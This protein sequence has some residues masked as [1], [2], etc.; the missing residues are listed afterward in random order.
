MKEQIEK[1]INGLVKTL[2]KIGTVIVVML[3]LANV[4]YAAVPISDG[5]DYPV[6]NRDNLEGW[7][8]SLSLGESWSLYYGHLGEDYLKNSASAK[9]EN[10]YSASNGVVY[11][12]YTGDPSGW[13]GVV[14]IKHAPSSGNSFSVSGLTLPDS[15]ETSINTVYTLYGHLNL[16]AIYVY[17]NENVGRGT[18]IGKIGLVEKFPTPHLHFEVKNQAAIDNEAHN[19]GTGHGYS[20][21]DNSAPNHYKPSNF[22][23]ANRPQTSPLIGDWNNDNIDET[24]TYN[25]R[26]LTFALDNGVTLVKSDTT[27]IPEAGDIALVGDWNKDGI[28]TVGV[29]RPKDAKFFLDNDNDGVIDPENDQ[30]FLFGNIGDY[31]I[32]GDWDKDGKDEVGVYRISDTDEN[33][34]TFFLKKSD[35]TSE[36]SFD[37]T[38]TDTPI[39][40]D[41]NNDGIDDVGVFRRNDPDHGENAV[42][43]LKFGDTVV[44]PILYGNNDDIP[45]AGK[46][47]VDKLTRVGIYRPNTGEFIF[48]P[49]P[50]F[51]SSGKL[52]LIF[53]V[54]TTG[55][56]WD[57]IDAVKA[58]ANEIVEALDF[59]GL[60]YRVTIANYKDYPCCGYGG[61]KDYVYKLDLP[62]TTKENK[63]DIIDAINNLGA[64]GGA[65]TPESVY[66]ALVHSMEDPNK[67][68]ANSANSGWRNGVTKAIII[69]GD[70]PPH[71]PELWSGGHTLADVI[72]TSESIDP[73]L[74]YSVIIG[75][76]QSAYDAFAEI[77]E[78]TNGNVYTSPT[79]NDVVAAILEAIGDISEPPENRGV[80]VN[81]APSNNE[82]TTGSSV[83]YAVNVTNIGSLNDAY[84]ISL[85]LNNF[86][87]FQR[88]YPAA[89][90][91]S[92]VNFNSAQISLDPGMSEVRPLTITV[93]QNWTGMED[94]V[95]TFNVTATSTTNA[96]IRNTSLAE[97]KVKADKRSMAE[98]SKLETVWLSDII[99]SSSIDQEIKDSLLDKL[100]NATLKLDQAISSISSGKY[101]Q[102]DN[103]LSASQNVINAFASQVEAQYDK[104]IMQPDAEMLKEKANQILQDL[105]AARNS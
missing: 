71:I 4:V 41:W 51:P 32:V 95:Y 79:A 42:F 19:G 2:G 84:D 44:D 24:G 100:T 82:A 104:K 88:G 16:T 29:Y 94:V 74:V 14:I 1:A 57:D 102:A 17:E 59:E 92:W 90:Q 34:A 23:A 9:G 105:E 86:A 28:D 62:F 26:T 53:L 37:I 64:S 36:I 10:V 11:K 45:I 38:P 87:G 103:M 50:V 75:S 46:P 54:D 30:E 91:P 76:S 93:P 55:S 69:M 15:G 77:S 80:L 13:G 40:A 83:G 56:M 73:V 97:L 5:F 68:P 52:D 47:Q 39:I 65:D 60:D 78:G 35:T 48:K 6:G 20:G 58:S 49:D 3:S 99:E 31:P 63:Q 27:N 96:S 72:S 8:K 89:I 67:D 101:P 18:K 66:S 81:I 43:Y 25:P 7:Y 85:E 21:T 98:Y 70:A 12:I 33:R 22:I 61:S